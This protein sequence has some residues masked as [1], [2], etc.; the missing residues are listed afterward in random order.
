MKGGFGL[1]SNFLKILI[2]F[3]AIATFADNEIYIDQS[4]ATANLDIE[5][6]GSSNIIGGLLSTANFDSIRFRWKSY[7][8]R[9]KS[10]RF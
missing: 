5:Q 10:N 9:Y 3:F 8:F 4:G 1:M 6:Q 7:D 2:L